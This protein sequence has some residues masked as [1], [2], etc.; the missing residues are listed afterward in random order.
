MN[1]HYDKF[2]FQGEKKMGGKDYFEGWYFKHV[3]ADKGSI[4]SFIPGISLN[5]EDTHAFVQCIY[6]NSEG[7]LTTHYFR[8]GIEAFTFNHEPFQVTVGKNTFSKEAI[9][10]DLKDNEMAISGKISYGKLKALKRTFSQPNIMGYFS[11]IPKMECNHE[12]I[13]MDHSLKGALVI[14]DGTVDFDDGRGY[15]EKDWG[16]SFPKKYIWIQSN[17]F[18]QEGISICCS[19]ATVPVAF[20]E[21]EG[22]FCNLVI[23]ED[24]YRFATYNQSKVQFLDAGGDDFHILLKNRHHKLFLKGKSTTTKEL[25]A[26]NNGKMAYTIK[27]GLTG[28][29]SL[30]LEDKD[31]HILMETKTGHSGIEIVGY[32]SN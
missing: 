12:I 29:V 24:E 26:P 25:V 11:Y 2:K 23:G 27:E 5:K 18:E 22:F 19:I 16:T 20:M 7:V 32:F 14:N 13:S 21:I 28:E 9:Y 10:V 6:K 8:Y 4:I 17:H 1:K 3:S 30:I 31:G 15:I